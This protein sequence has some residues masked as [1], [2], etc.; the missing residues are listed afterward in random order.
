MAHSYCLVY[1]CPPKWQ[2]PGD[3][4]GAPAMSLVS[5]SIDYTV[6]HYVISSPSGS[7]YRQCDQGRLFRTTVPRVFRMNINQTNTVGTKKNKKIK[8]TPNY[9]STIDHPTSLGNSLSFFPSVSVR[10]SEK[11]TEYYTVP[12]PTSCYNFL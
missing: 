1:R 5:I 11:N 12:Q 2:A 9:F 7:F 4:Y 8:K 6:S 10:C 3:I